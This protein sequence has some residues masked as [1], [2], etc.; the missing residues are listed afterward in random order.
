[1][2]CADVEEY[3]KTCVKCQMTKHS[4]QSKIEKL[5]PLP[6][7]KHNFYSISMDFMTRIPKVAG[8]DAVMVFMCYLNNWAVFVLCSKQATAEEVTQLFLDNWIRHKGFPW[9]IVNNHGLLFQTEY[10]QYMMWRIG[11]KL[12]M[13]MA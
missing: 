10:W 13:T 3:A 6:I 11:V 4:T 7:F 12:L 8:N 1:M 5:R 2:A 9:D